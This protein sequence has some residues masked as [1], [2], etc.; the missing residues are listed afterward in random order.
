MNKDLN[1]LHIANNIFGRQQHHRCSLSFNGL[2]S[3]Y[4]VRQIVDIMIKEY[5][6]ELISI[7]V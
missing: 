6:L 7:L 4:S 1:M 2:I 5:L 3:L